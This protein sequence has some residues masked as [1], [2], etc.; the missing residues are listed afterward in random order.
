MSNNGRAQ[1]RIFTVDTPLGYRVFLTR[2][3]WRQIVRKKHPALAGQEKK[4]RTCLES[5]TVVRESSKDSDVHLYYVPSSDVFLCV[6][7]APSNDDERFVVT[8]YFTE[9]IKK[10]KE[11]WT[12]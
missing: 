3:R 7:A 12:S 1:R 10:G 9:N 11:L 4:V 5:P 2:D 8:A 6:V